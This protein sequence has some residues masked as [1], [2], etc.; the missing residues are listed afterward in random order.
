MAVMEGRHCLDACSLCIVVSPL[1]AEPYLCVL[2]TTTFAMGLFTVI[3]SIMTFCR[4]VRHPRIAIVCAS[5]VAMHYALC[6][7]MSRVMYWG[8]G[9]TNSQ[10]IAYFSIL[11]FESV[12][13]VSVMLSTHI[14]MHYIFF[15][16]FY[17]N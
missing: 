13:V 1:I 2:I 17:S 5:F 8:F 9:G 6:A 14:A 7:N 15:A 11:T 4:H 16:T 3:M 10:Q 12:K